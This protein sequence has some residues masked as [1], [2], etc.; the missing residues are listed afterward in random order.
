MARLQVE[1]S[2][3]KH[4][5]ARYTSQFGDLD[6]PETQERISLN[7]TLG[8]QICQVK[9]QNA[10]LQEELKGAQSDNDRLWKKMKDSETLLEERE[11]DYKKEIEEHKNFPKSLLRN[12]LGTKMRLEN[13]EIIV[14]KFTVELGFFERCTEECSCTDY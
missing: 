10:E 9:L 4:T 1:V 13:F 11:E 6:N 8:E 12:S 7:E 2:S 3:L 14:L 5:Q